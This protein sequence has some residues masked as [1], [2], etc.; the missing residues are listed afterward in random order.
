MLIVLYFIIINYLFIH[1]D[2][3]ILEFNYFFTIAS[4]DHYSEIFILYS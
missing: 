4:V 2:R 1:F 3:E